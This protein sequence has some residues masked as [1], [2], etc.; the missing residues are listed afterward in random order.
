VTVPALEPEPTQHS[1]P[2][3][4]GQTPDKEVKIN[5]LFFHD[6]GYIE[7]YQTSELSPNNCR[8]SGPTKEVCLE[9]TVWPELVRDMPPLWEQRYKK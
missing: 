6:S 1:K 4:S 5:H 8:L 9:Q 3:L 7:P 2:A